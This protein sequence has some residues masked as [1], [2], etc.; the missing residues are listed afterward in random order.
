M[1]S[2]PHAVAARPKPDLCTAHKS[3]ACA[4]PIEGKALLLYIRIYAANN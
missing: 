1:P 4:M 3:I 2:R